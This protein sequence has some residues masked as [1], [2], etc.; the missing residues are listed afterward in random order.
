MP[1]SFFFIYHIY[2]KCGFFFGLL[3][4]VLRLKSIRKYIWI[5]LFDVYFVLRRPPT[6]I[7]AHRT[8]QSGHCTYTRISESSTQN[9]NTA[10]NSQA[11]QI[12]LLKKKS[13]ESQSFETADNF[14]G[15]V[16]YSFVAQS[17]V[18]IG[19][20]IHKFSS[21][22]KS[23]FCR[24]LWVYLYIQYKWN[25]VKQLQ[26]NHELSREKKVPKR[27]QSKLIKQSVLFCLFIHYS[28]SRFRRRDIQ[29]FFCDTIR[30]KNEAKAKD[31]WKIHE[32]ILKSECHRAAIYSLFA[33]MLKTQ[34]YKHLIIS[35]CSCTA[36]LF[37]M[38][39][40]LIYFPS[41]SL[42]HSKPH[43]YWWL[44]EDVVCAW[45]FA[46]LLRFENGSILG[47][48][49]IRWLRSFLFFFLFLDQSQWIQ[50]NKTMRKKRTKITVTSIFTLM[51]MN[52]MGNF[53]LAVANALNKPLIMSTC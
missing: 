17:S 49:S 48:F 39:N 28:V 29:A 36:R 41:N 10:Q 27:N 19:L 43:I 35:Y 33:K 26:S 46:L 20:L 31:K 6:R 45:F 11:N 52:L 5:D 14:F 30:K 32:S 51:H 4:S 2:H 50:Q 7:H 44:S 12:H 34:N 25:K 9:H 1:W 23:P 40:T 8:T 37:D 24:W 47:V 13:N 53:K 21:V 38:L 18:Q 16:S 3:K 15:F 42:A 22:D